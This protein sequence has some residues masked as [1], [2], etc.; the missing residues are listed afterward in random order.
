MCRLEPVDTMQMETKFMR[1]PLAVT[2]GSRFGDWQVTWIGGWDKWRLYYMV[3]VVKVPRQAY[4]ESQAQSPF[5]GAP[6]V[7]ARRRARAN[8][9]RK[10]LRRA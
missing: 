3:M 5:A 2:V 1:I 9:N 6:K 8:R 10:R 7:G 4:D